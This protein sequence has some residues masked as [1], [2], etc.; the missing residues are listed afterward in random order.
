MKKVIKNRYP[1]INLTIFYMDIQT[2]EREFDRTLDRAQNDI[3][4]I[5]AMPS[6]I[7]SDEDGFPRVVY[8][9][10]DETRRVTPF[11]LVVLSVGIAPRDPD[12]PG[13]F[14]ALWK[15]RDGFIGS[16][17]NDVD[18]GHPGIFVAGAAQGPKS[19]SACVSHAILAA[20]QI[21]RYLDRAMRG[22]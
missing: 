8:H 18:A 10:G 22:E 5:R 16:D 20:S 7:H 14:P 12:L 13:S 3:N 15:N 17:D 6:E 1:D 2:F 19:I 4:F 21:K 9:G 11:D